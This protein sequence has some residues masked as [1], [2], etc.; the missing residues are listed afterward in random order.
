MINFKEKTYS[1]ETKSIF[2]T[3]LCQLEG[4]KCRVKNLHWAA[5]RKNIH[6]YLDEFLDI[7]SDYQDALAEGYMGIL[8]QMNP[9]DINPV[10]CT[11]DN[12]WDMI[13]DTINKTNEFY[14]QIPEGPEFKG[15]VSETETLIQNEYKYKYLFG[16][17]Q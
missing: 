4:I 8:G 9:L 15:I 5:P 17:C 3:F 12:A 7:I 11:K 10:P 6:V 2:L 16:L 13:E 14:T 1:E